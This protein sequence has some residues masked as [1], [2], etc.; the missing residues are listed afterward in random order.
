M[1]SPDES[2]NVCKPLRICCKNPMTGFLEV[3]GVIPATKD[4]GVH[5]VCAIVTDSFLAFSKEK[6]ND[7]SAP[8]PE[9]DFPGLKEGVNGVYVP[10]DG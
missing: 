6:G 9:Y 3:D 1:I 7:L 5:T 4:Q 10:E 8:I 2:V